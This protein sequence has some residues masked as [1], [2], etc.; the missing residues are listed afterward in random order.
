[1]NR[2]YDTASLTWPAAWLNVIGNGQGA[3]QDVQPTS[4]QVGLPGL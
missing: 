2:S 4:F 3:L 1:M